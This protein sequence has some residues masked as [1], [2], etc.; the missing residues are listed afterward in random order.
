MS[1]LMKSAMGFEV[2]MDEGLE[3]EICNIL[4]LMENNSSSVAKCELRSATESNSWVIECSWRDQQAMNAHFSS[5]HLQDLI[6]LLA[7][8]SRR[9]VFGCD[10]E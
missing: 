2:S 8:R 5:C 3:G 9:I 7:S 1:G 4:G 10:R 6:G